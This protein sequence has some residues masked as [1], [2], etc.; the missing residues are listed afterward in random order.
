MTWTKEREDEIRSRWAGQSSD[1]DAVFS[2]LDAEREARQRAEALLATID[3]HTAHNDPMRVTASALARSIQRAERER[4]EAREKVEMWRAFAKDEGVRAARTLGTG[5]RVNGE[6][7]T[8]RDEARAERDALAAQLATLRAAAERYAEVAEVPAGHLDT[9]Q[10]LARDA[11]R[12]ALA[13][14]PGAVRERKERSAFDLADWFDAKARWSAE[15]FGPET[16]PQRYEAVV[17]HIRKELVEI[18]RDPADLEE[19][20]DVVMLAMDGAWRSAGADGAAFVAML[21]GKHAINLVRV[22]R[23]G[24][25]G[26]I[27]HVREEVAVLEDDGDPA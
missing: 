27:E 26:V 2:W 10:D 9:I 21:E 3:K 24:D 8:A 22:W 15:V 16:G 23:R 11:L 20:C 5:F 4:D 25:D 1:V 18:E 12:A 17:A 13:D 19:W 6:V 14:L 7:M